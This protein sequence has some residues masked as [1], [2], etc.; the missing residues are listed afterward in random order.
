VCDLDRARGLLGALDTCWPISLRNARPCASGVVF[1]FS[2]YESGPNS[3]G[4]R[5]LFIPWTELA[6]G[7]AIPSQPVQDHEGVDQARP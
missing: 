7:A 4:A 3:F 6:A 5:D 2:A 1:A